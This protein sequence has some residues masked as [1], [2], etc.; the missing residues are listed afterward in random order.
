MKIIVGDDCLDFARE[1]MPYIPNAEVEFVDDPAEIVFRASSDAYD[2]VITDLSYTPNGVEGF[3]VLEALLG[4]TA[5]RILWT[6]AAQ[7]PD[8]RRRALE[9]GAEVLDK[10][11]LGSLVGLAVSEAPL[12]TDGQVLIFVT[13]LLS[14]PNRALA[15]VV[16]ALF[17]PGQVVVSNSLK[18]ELM[19]GKYGLVIDTSTLLMPGEKQVRMHGIVAHDLKYFRLPVVPRV[20]CVHDVTKV[21]VEIATA[22]GRFWNGQ[23]KLADAERI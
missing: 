12:K 15:Q 10:P 18:D 5:R 1:S 19:S 11:E 21:V 13:D 9:L 2:I 8:V 4:T 23:G 20:V 22:I 16:H 14:P 3:Q 17:K 6:G 7:E